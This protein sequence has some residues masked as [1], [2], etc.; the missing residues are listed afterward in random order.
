MT[1][2]LSLLA[3]DVEFRRLVT[4]LASQIA[5]Y[6][7]VLSNHPFAYHFYTDRRAM[8]LLNDIYLF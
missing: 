5:A 1:Q 4:L 3:S 7:N 6:A 2:P 8:N